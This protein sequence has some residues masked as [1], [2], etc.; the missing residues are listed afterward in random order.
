MAK[1]TRRKD[2]QFSGLFCVVVM[3]DNDDPYYN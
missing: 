2:S 1:R 3:N